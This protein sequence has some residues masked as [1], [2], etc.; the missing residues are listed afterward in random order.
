[1]DGE[2]SHIDMERTQ[3]AK[4]NSQMRQRLRYLE[5]DKKDVSDKYVQLNA[6]YRALVRKYDQEV[7]D[8]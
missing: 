1:M 8:K 5:A 3:L 6:D 4:E 2:F 7:R